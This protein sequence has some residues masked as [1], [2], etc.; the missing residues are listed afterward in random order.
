MKK[1]VPF[2][3]NLN[4]KTKI[5]EITSISVDNTLKLDNQFVSGEFIISGTY[6]IMSDSKTEEEFNYQI[7]VDINI[8]NKYDTTKCQISI[9]DFSYEIINEDILKVNISVLLDELY[10]KEENISEEKIEREEI[11][12]DDIEEI[13]TSDVFSEKD[14]KEEIDNNIK[15]E[16]DFQNKILNNMDTTKEYSVYRVYNVKE[17]DTIDLILEKYNISKEILS[18]YNDLDNITIGSKIIIPSIDE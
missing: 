14:T 11:I 15:D 6:K 7:P 3:K 2:T 1:I 4:F 5:G 18:E 16:H 12:L 10:T 13:N 8:D 17:N 9:D